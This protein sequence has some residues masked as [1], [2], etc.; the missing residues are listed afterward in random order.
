MGKTSRSRDK[1]PITRP[2]LHAETPFNA[3]NDSLSQ[4]AMSNMDLRAVRSMIYSN[5]P[6]ALTGHTDVIEYNQTRRPRVYGSRSSSPSHHLNPYTRTYP[7]PR[8]ALSRPSFRRPLQSLICIRRNIRKQ[9][10]FAAFRSRM[11]RGS[12]FRK[13]RYNQFSRVRC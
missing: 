5:T 6:V 12:S 10:L 9:V 3:F 7:G 2:R 11:G 4:M 13:P 1:T 8:Q